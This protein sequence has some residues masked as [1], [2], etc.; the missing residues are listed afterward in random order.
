MAPKLSELIYYFRSDLFVRFFPSV[1]IVSL[2]H[3]LLFSGWTVLSFFCPYFTLF[4]WEC[5][6][7]MCFNSFA[8][9]TSFIC[10]NSMQFRC[11]NTFFKCIYVSG[12]E[13]FTF[14]YRFVDPYFSPAWS[15]WLHEF[16]TRG[17]LGDMMRLPWRGDE[18]KAGF[19]YQKQGFVHL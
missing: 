8:I 13:Y 16:D 6:Y 9:T 12:F 5:L 19:Q 18:G 2:F 14:V 15:N 11:F 7:C 17:R 10:L 4:L 3:S 1:G